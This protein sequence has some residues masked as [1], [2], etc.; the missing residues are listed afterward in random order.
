MAVDQLGGKD[1]KT[2]S[3]ETSSLNDDLGAKRSIE[4]R[5]SAL[6]SRDALGSLHG[7]E[8][9]RVIIFDDPSEGIDE[10]IL[11]EYDECSLCA[12]SEVYCISSRTK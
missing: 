7:K 2:K 3:E 11:C 5:L 12:V 10:K 4:T 8:S 6:P 9:S 1:L